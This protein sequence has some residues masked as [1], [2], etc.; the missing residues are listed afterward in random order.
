M[1]N[2]VDF[3]P[4]YCAE[5]KSKF[6]KIF[7]NRKCARAFSDHDFLKKSCDLNFDA[8]DLIFCEDLA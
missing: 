3:S 8:K 5:K 6:S 4:R 7:E 2:Y 1:L